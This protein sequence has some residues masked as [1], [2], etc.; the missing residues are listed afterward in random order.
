MSKTHPYT[1]RPNTDY[2][3][4]VFERTGNPVSDDGTDP[5]IDSLATGADCSALPGYRVTGVSRSDVM[6]EQE[7]EQEQQ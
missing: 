7:Y 3:T 4:V 6:S 5:F 2:L 1:G